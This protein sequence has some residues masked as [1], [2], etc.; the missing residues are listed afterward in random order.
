MGAEA[1]PN[2][3]GPRRRPA[4]ALQGEIAARTRA[5]RIGLTEEDAV[6]LAAASSR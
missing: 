1:I 4:T 6:H 2:H 3:K 5:E